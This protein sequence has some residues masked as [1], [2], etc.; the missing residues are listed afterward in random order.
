MNL[1][2]EIEHWLCEYD[3]GKCSGTEATDQILKAVEARL[4]SNDITWTKL[5]DRKFIALQE[6]KELL[7]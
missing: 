1:R 3:V 4:C 2:D 7:K 5:G 6:V